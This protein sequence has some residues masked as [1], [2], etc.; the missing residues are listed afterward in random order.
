MAAPPSATIDCIKA[1]LAS[2]T[3]CSEKTVFALQQLLSIHTTETEDKIQRA[4][5]KGRAKASTKLFSADTSRR[6][7]P[8]EVRKS[9]APAAYYDSK[10]ALSEVNKLVLATDVVNATLKALSE[11]IKTD[12]NHP[13]LQTTSITAAKKTRDENEPPKSALPKTNR[14]ERLPLQNVTKSGSLNSLAQ[15]QQSPKVSQSDNSTGETAPWI[16]A[17]AR[18][19]DIAFEYLRVHEKD[20]KLPALQLENGLLALVGKCLPHSITSLALKELRILKKRLDKHLNGSHPRQFSNNGQEHTGSVGDLLHFDSATDDKDL[21]ALVIGHQLYVLK[22]MGLLRQP[23]L[24]EEAIKHIH[25]TSYSPMTLLEEQAACASLRDKSAQQLDRLSQ[26]LLLLCSSS[27]SAEQVTEA[28]VSGPLSATTAL[29]LQYTAIKSRILLWALIGHKPEEDKELW[30]PLSR[31]LS[32]YAR[33]SPSS[34]MQKFQV[35][36][37]VYSTIKQYAT[38]HGVELK[39]TAATVQADVMDMVISMGRAAGRYNDIEG[40]MKLRYEEIVKVARRISDAKLAT[41]T[42]RMAE[43]SL[44]ADVSNDQRLVQLTNALQRLDGSLKGTLSE[45]CDLIQ[46]LSLL[47]KAATKTYIEARFSEDVPENVIAGAEMCCDIV[48][49]CVR[50]LLRFFIQPKKSDAPANEQFDERR[51]T[52]A[53]LSVGFI[54]SVLQCCKHQN[55]ETLPNIEKVDTALQDSFKL[56][57]ELELD[58][59]LVVKISNAYWLL[60]TRIQRLQGVKSGGGIKMMKRSIDVLRNRSPAEQ[61]DGFFATKLEKLAEEYSAT[62]ELAHAHDLLIQAARHY[63]GAGVLKSAAELAASLPPHRISSSAGPSAVLGRMLGHINR[64]LINIDGTKAGGASYFDDEALPAEERGIL[65]EWQLELMLQ[66]LP[67]TRSVNSVGIIRL[68]KLVES[69]LSLYSFKHFPVRLLRVL[70]TVYRH[71]EDVPTSLAEKLDDIS[72]IYGDGQIKDLA[73]DANLSKY[74]KD[75]L[76]TLRVY[77]TFGSCYVDND[78]LQQSLQEWQSIVDSSRSWSALEEQINNF[79]DWISGLIFIADYF[80]MKGLPRL[81]IPT[82]SLIIRALELQEPSNTMQ[83]STFLCKLG[84]QYSR[85]GY[86]ANAQLV[87]DK[88]KTLLGDDVSRETKLKWSLAYGEYLLSI[89]SLEDCATL[90]STATTCLAVELSPAITFTGRMQMAK[91]LAEASYTYAVYYL[92][93]GDTE[94]AFR[95]GRRCVKLNQRMWANLENRH[96]PKPLDAKP[97]A[98]SGIGAIT[99]DIASLGTSTDTPV[100]RSLTHEALKVPQLWPLVPSLYQGFKLLARLFAHHGQ[101]QE[102]LHYAEQALRIAAAVQSTS[103]L[104]DIQS[105]IASFWLSVGKTSKAQ[106]CLDVIKGLTVESDDNW[107]R[108]NFQL[109]AAEMSKAKNELDNEIK[110]YNAALQAIDKMTDPST[111]ESICT[112]SS[113]Q[114]QLATRLNKLRPEKRTPATKCSRRVPRKKTASK[115][116]ED[117]GCK[118]SATESVIGPPV[119]TSSWVPLEELR[120]SIL[121]SKV[122]ANVIQQKLHEAKA[123]LQQVGALQS[124]SQIKIRKHVASFHLIFANAFEVLMSD[125]F[126]VIPE[127][128]I[129][130]PAVASSKIE[131]VAL[132][133]CESNMLSIERKSI[134]AVKTASTRKKA[135]PGFVIAEDLAST[136]LSAR[137]WLQD[138]QDVAVRTASTAQLHLLYALLTS[139]SILLSAV[140]QANVEVKIHPLTIA[141]FLDYP[142]NRV[143][144]REQAIVK[145]ENENENVNPATLLE[146]P[147]FSSTNS[148]AVRMSGVEFQEKYIDI[149][150]KGWS[151]ISLSINEAKDELHI[152]RYRAGQSPFILRLPMARHNSRDAD[153]E[154]FGFNEGQMELSEVINLA[155]F[156][157]Q[158]AKNMSAKGAKTKWW[159]AREALDARMRDLLVNVENIWLGGFRGIFAQQPQ[160]PQLLANFQRDLINILNRHIPSRRAR[161]HK[162]I[163]LDPRILELFTGLG[164][165]TE[166]GVDLDEP[167]MDLLY[168]VVDILQFNGEQIAYDEVDF[169]LVSPHFFR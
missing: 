66:M 32:S 94:A 12:L 132:E 58:G 53:R 98:D 31:Y 147:G 99:D 161:A 163:N 118:A 55:T 96:N 117:D 29:W 102:A 86:S 77:R 17:T 87:Y 65:L 52:I 157:A 152:C 121:S 135:Q 6:S 45:V 64:L 70:V 130:L 126:N 169:D 104:V 22:L 46:E 13:R 75:L 43:I 155:N 150:P 88:S 3:A 19:A 41:L 100:V 111:I 57:E 143:L 110:G 9:E 33:R 54:A 144:Q 140:T 79:P 106:D 38:D 69:L 61:T 120:V 26:S 1:S 139:V 73:N 18:C 50:V 25:N 36:S 125:T 148:E 34:A 83:L 154:L 47:R 146:W 72:A 85:I 90:L 127:S 153:E 30:L 62:K 16:V 109:V 14:R 164:D 20:T 151:V 42:A 44:I 112:F 95:Y 103:R 92:E 149:I 5:N 67:S 122:E 51:A 141:A 108:L 165:P 131:S 59:A 101:F 78:K 114:D 37:T 124:G 89:N 68:A 76:A 40:V 158:D 56:I 84:L 107:D 91:L 166:D 168:F 7:T 134:K 80:D 49:R 27:Q 129:A 71:K 8:K 105:M 116:S 4:Q 119:S 81:L 160:Q 156:S 11:A 23:K 159:E 24:A 21:R 115:T 48:F 142:R 60:Y 2:P 137:T 39:A 10:S 136:L 162:P 145:A 82:L 138:V 74:E 133:N 128:T 15:N 93:T 63:L 28:E 35:V 113:M 167:L 123:L 97:D